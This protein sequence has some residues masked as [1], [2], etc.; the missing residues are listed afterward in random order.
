MGFSFSEEMSGTVEW[1]A[2]PGVTHPM[3]FEVT[4]QAESTLAHLRDGLAT[5][6]GT[7]TVPPRAN[8]VPVEG[9]LLIRPIGQKV[10]RYE[11]S[12]VG[13][14]GKPYEL[15]GQKDILYRHLSRTMRFL[16]AEI[17][18]EDHRRVATCK[19][20]FDPRHTLRFLGSFRPIR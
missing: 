18:D 17:L 6:R 7:I 20:H 9:T 1:D 11:L 8:A 4:A 16:P 3:K 15:V 19:T 2:T 14:D 12:F 10:I 13:D 5:L